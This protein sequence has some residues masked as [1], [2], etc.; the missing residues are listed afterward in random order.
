VEKPKDTRLNLPSWNVRQLDRRRDLREW[1]RW[2]SFEDLYR[3]TLR[4][5]ELRA[6]W[7]AEAHPEL[8]TAELLERLTIEEP[9]LSRRRDD[10]RTCK[11]WAIVSA[12]TGRSLDGDRST[13]KD[14]GRARALRRAYLEQ[15]PRAKRLLRYEAC[16]KD[17]QAYPRRRFHEEIRRLRKRGPH[18]ESLLSLSS[19]DYLLPP[20]FD[21]FLLELPSPSDV[22]VVVIFGAPVRTA[23]ARLQSLR[24]D[25]PFARIWNG[26]VAQLDDH[27]VARLEL[28]TALFSHQAPILRGSAQTLRLAIPAA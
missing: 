26:F 6:E 19:G 16:R 14:I 23:F 4:R 24:A 18:V 3:E 12:L 2:L 8:S 5:L 20:H 25:E 11:A 28:E 15:E 27:R 7:I 21:T 10:I 17:L 13:A 1:A 22:A 9:F